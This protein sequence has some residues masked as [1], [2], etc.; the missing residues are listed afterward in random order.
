MP[1]VIA[2]NWPVLWLIMC[3]GFASLFLATLRRRK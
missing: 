3:G 2:E 1:E